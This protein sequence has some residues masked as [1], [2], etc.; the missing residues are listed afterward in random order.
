MFTDKSIPTN[1]VDEHS[2][3]MPHPKNSRGG[4]R[5]RRK[6]LLSPNTL[7][8]IFQ[9]SLVRLGEASIGY[10]IDTNEAGG[11]VIITLLGAHLCQEKKHLISTEPCEECQRER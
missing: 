2:S 8:S 10:A 4:R 3:S 7:L 1:T 5:G 9:S 6:N 11:S